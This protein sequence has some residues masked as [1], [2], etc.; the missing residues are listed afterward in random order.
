[1]RDA[2]HGVERVHERIA[3]GVLVERVDEASVGAR[4]ARERRAL[5]HPIPLRAVGDRAW[6]EV[7]GTQV[8]RADEVAVE[9]RD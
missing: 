4:G 2:A 9:V 8:V 6:E 5:H 7:V 1:M 3:A